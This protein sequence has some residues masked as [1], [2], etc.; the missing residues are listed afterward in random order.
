M[1][2]REIKKL[3]KVWSWFFGGYGLRFWQW[4]FNVSRKRRHCGVFST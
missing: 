3:M 4:C 2:V 1:K